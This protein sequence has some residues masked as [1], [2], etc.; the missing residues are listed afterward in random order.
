V[1][2]QTNVAK[3]CG[4]V[5]D[6]LSAK[7]DK[8]AIS[9]RSLSI[10][11]WFM[12]PQAVC[13]AQT[14]RI[15]TN[16]VFLENSIFEICAPLFDSLAENSVRDLFLSC[17]SRANE[18]EAALFLQ[19]V[20][21]NSLVNAGINV[22]LQTGEN[23]QTDSSRERASQL[24]VILEDWNLTARKSTGDEPE[25]HIIVEFRL[26]LRY[27]L[28]NQAGKV[29]STRKLSG[30]KSGFYEDEKNFLFTQ[31]KQ[32]PFARARSQFTSQNNN[33]LSTILIAGV[34]GITVF[35]IYSLRSQ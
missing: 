21:L 31:E 17:K 29:L 18:Q 16:S 9:W 15:E 5:N 28:L 20:L 19:D 33:L 32:P 13:F 8:M 6:Y 4:R 7:L 23:A 10:I 24:Y 27:H 12:I 3:T 2:L 26:Q 14:T 35:L 34:T 22:Y 30:T 1:K 25:K 11:F